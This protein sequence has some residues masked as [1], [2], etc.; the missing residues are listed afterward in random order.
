MSTPNVIVQHVHGSVFPA[1]IDPAGNPAWYQR[2]VGS[3]PVVVFRDGRR[4]DGRWNRPRATSGTQLVDAQGRPITLS[5]GGAWFVLVN[6]GTP[7]AG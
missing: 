3:G 6:T 5:P 1:D 4:I 7:L 2:T